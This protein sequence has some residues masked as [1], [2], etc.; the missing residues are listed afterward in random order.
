MTKFNQPNTSH[1][2][3]TAGSDTIVGAHFGR[4]DRRTDSLALVRGVI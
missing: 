1:V 2:C 3:D 4:A